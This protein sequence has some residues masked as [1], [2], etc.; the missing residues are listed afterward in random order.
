MA[1]VSVESWGGALILI[2]IGGQG[3]GEAFVQVTPKLRAE[4]YL[5][6]PKSI[7]MA[8]PGIFWCFTSKNL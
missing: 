2:W 7:H 5:S 3:S 1:D 6:Y 8:Q 4:F